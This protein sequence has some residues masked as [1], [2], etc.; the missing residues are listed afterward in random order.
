MVESCAVSR[1]GYF[2]IGKAIWMVTAECSGLTYPTNIPPPILFFHIEPPKSYLWFSI[3]NVAKIGIFLLRGVIMEHDVDLEDLLEGLDAE[4]AKIGV[5][6]RIVAC[7]GFVLQRRYYED[8][9]SRKTADVDSISHLTDQIRLAAMQVGQTR[10]AGMGPDVTFQWLNDRVLEGL[11]L[12]K[13]LPEGWFERSLEEQAIFEGPKGFLLI[14]PLPQFEMI[15]TKLH[16]VLGDLTSGSRKISAKFE[17]D[18]RDLK[19][20]GYN[21]DMIADL[22]HAFQKMMPW[23]KRIF[24]SKDSILA[25]LEA[26]AK[27]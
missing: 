1:L 22:G 5:R 11:R 17:Q 20:L 12:D 27:D 9:N 15:L 3:V 24:T 13:K 26:L 19:A 8:P 2:W 23:R 21:A 25:R 18:L 10:L 6:Y 14:F 7:G 4:L 16:A